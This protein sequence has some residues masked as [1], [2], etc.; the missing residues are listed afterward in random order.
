MRSHWFKKRHRNLQLNLIKAQ[1]DGNGDL[2][3]RLLQEKEHLMQ[4]EKKG[5]PSLHHRYDTLKSREI[6]NG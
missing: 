2:C 5:V 4:E 3:L 1:Q 6:P